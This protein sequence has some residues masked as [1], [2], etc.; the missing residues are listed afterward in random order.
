MDLDRQRAFLEALHAAASVVRDDQTQALAVRQG[1]S[2]AEA[3]EAVQAATEI[4][5]WQFGCPPEWRV[6]RLA[7]ALIDDDRKRQGNL[8]ATRGREP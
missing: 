1:V 3:R 4:L 8:F 6:L 2:V 5:E 7:Q